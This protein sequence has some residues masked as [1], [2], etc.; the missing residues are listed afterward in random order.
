MAVNGNGWRRIVLPIALVVL[1]GLGGMLITWGSRG[2]KVSANVAGVLENKLNIVI[3]QASIQLNRE[4]LARHGEMLLSV[5]EQ[6]T[7]IELKLDRV[8]GVGR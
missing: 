7:R 2:E 6:L 1:G 5:K 3:N 8:I 4:T